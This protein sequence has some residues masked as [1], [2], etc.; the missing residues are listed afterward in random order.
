M[1]DKLSSQWVPSD[2]LPAQSYGLKLLYLP[3]LSQHGITPMAGV[4]REKDGQLHL[5]LC[6]Q[7][8]QQWGPPH[9]R[10]TVIWNQGLSL[11]NQ[12]HISSRMPM[13][14]QRHHISGKI[15]SYNYKHLNPATRTPLMKD[16]PL[17]ETQCWHES[18]VQ[19]LFAGAAYAPRLNTS[20]KI[21][22]KAQLC[23]KGPNSSGVQINILQ[24]EPHWPKG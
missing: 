12:A 11:K 20:V 7:Q 21:W 18:L 22:H 2:S 10:S 14:T 16:Q 13:C 9:E 6:E 17:S 19:V 3:L 8:N 24:K 23:V 5:C 4:S 1:S 15:L